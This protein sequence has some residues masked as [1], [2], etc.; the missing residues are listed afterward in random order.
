M[1]KFI[2]CIVFIA[3]LAFAIPSHA[4]V[5]NVYTYSNGGYRRATPA[6]ISRTNFVKIPPQAN[7]ANRIIINSPVY[8][9]FVVTPPPPPPKRE[10]YQYN[11]FAGTRRFPHRSYYIPSYC[12]PVSRFYNNNHNPFCAQYMPYGNSMYFRF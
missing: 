10:K 11:D 2:Y 12:L 9:R 6:E 5:H 8:D 3:L 1:K 4:M 7:P